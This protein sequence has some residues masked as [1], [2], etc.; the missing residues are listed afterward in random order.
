[1]QTSRV[2]CTGCIRC[3]NNTMIPLFE[4][5]TQ[6][7][8]PAQ[9]QNR[10]IPPPARIATSIGPFGPVSQLADNTAQ[11]SNKVKG[12]CGQPG[13]ETHQTASGSLGGQKD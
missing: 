11:H 1:M 6:L 4:R 13:Q 2:L 3:T 10:G 12:P 5:P 9:S 7:A 8:K